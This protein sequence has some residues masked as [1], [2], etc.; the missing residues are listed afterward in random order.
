MPRNC[1]NSYGNVVPVPRL[2]KVRQLML[3]RPFKSLIA[4]IAIVA[5]ALSLIV[6]FVPAA[7]A[8]D[9]SFNYAEGGTGPVATF[10]ATDQDGDPAV[11][12]LSG[13]DAD[14]FTIE[15]GVLA[16]KKSPNYESPADEGSDNTYDVTLRAS[17]GTRDVVVIV[18]NVDEMGSVDID[19]L[20]PQAG[21][22][23][24]ASVS[25]QD[26][27]S[28]DQE[29]WQWSK[30]MSED[31]EFSDISGATSPTYTPKTDDIGYFLQ[32]TATYSDGIGEGRDSASG[33]TVF[34]VE[35]RP[36]SNAQ[37]VFADETPV[38]S[39]T[40]SE[41]TRTV[42]E[43]AKP[44]DSVGNPVTA[45]DA[46]N[47]PRLYKLDGLAIVYTSSTATADATNPLPTAIDNSDALFE[48]DRKTGQI[49]L[50]SDANTRFLNVEEYVT[51]EADS[52][53]TPPT[54]QSLEYMVKVTATDPSGSE[55]E[56][57]VT[58]KVA[59]VDEAP[60]ITLVTAGLGADQT[61]RIV[62][63]G[64]TFVVT[65]PEERALALRS[66]EGGA[67]AFSTGLPVFNARDPEEST[68]A[69]NADRDKITW[70]ISGADAKRFEIAKIVDGDDTSATFGQSAPNAGFN[71]S[72]ALRWASENNEGPSFEAMDSA[73]GDNVYL[74]T[75]TAFDG[76]SSTSQAV[77]I[78]VRNEEE[79]GSITLSQLTP[80]VG[81]SV[82]ASL[83]D[84]DKGVTGAE[85]QWYR[86]GPAT[87]TD[88]PADGIQEDEIVTLF[89]ALGTT[90]E[91][92][93]KFG[94]KCDP[95]SAT[96]AERTNCWIEGA[97]S[98]TY[99]PVTADTTGGPDDSAGDPTAQRLTAVVRYTDT[100]MTDNDTRNADGT[101]TAGTPDEK[102]DGDIAIATTDNAATPRPNQN[103]A[104][105]FGDD[106][107]VDR[108]VAENAKDANV[109]EPVTANDGDADA[110]LYSLSGDGHEAFK[111]DRKNG[112]IK[113]AKA[114]DFETQS[115]YSITL[116]ATD[117]SGAS[118]SITVNVEVTD[119]DDA[120]TI[121]AVSSL[122]Y[123]EGG[124]D[125]VAT[126]T[127][128]DQDGDA[129][130]WS[131]GGADADLFTI[132]GGVLA[133]KKSPNYE[134]P[135]DEGS[136][137]IYDVTVR[138][139]GGTTDVVVTVTNV[140]EMGS[141]DIDDLQPQAGESMTASVSDQDSSSL[142]QERWQWSKSMSE[143]G[144][145]S[146]ISGA[147]S[148]TYTP[149]TDDIGYFLQATATY[150]D[151]IGE[152]RDS[153]SGVTVFAVEK[154]P[155]SNAQPVFADETPVASPTTSEQTRTV[156]ETAKPG[157]SVGN[158][159]TASDA[160][161]DPRLYKLDGLAITY[162]S[163]TATADAT[164]PLPTAIGNSDALF[165]I[166]RK[167]GQIS[168]KSDAN[169]RF[170]NVEEYVTTEADST[171]TP[172]TPQS[173]EYMVKV[174]ATD[175]SGSEGEV[176]VTIKVAAVD[177][178]PAITLVTTGL[179]TGQ[180]ARIVTPGQT[181]VVTTPE[182]RALALRSQEG[183]ADA[184][185]TGLPVFNA[186][187]PEESTEATNADR[188][189]ITWSISGADAK[190]FEIAKIVNADGDS[191]PNDNFNSSAALRW[192]SENNEGPS[193]EAMDSADGDNVY[194]VTV[195]AFDG[196]SSTSQAVSITVR[197]EEE[198]G[199][200]TLSQL[201]PQVGIS[202]T[203]S[204]DDPDKG[205]TGAE[206]QWYRGGGT[207]ADGDTPADG[208]QQ[209]EIEAVFGTLATTGENAGKFGAKCD[210]TSTTPAER[211]NCWIEGATSSTYTPVAAD[212]TGGPA[213]SAGD[214]TA[215]RL[216]AVVRYT[217]TVVTTVSAT[218]DTEVIDI[219][220]AT[221][222]NAATPRPNQNSA[223]S[224][225]DDESVDR[226]VAE[227]AKDANVG[228]PVTANDGDADALLYSLSGDG[229]EAFK[230]D[231]KNGQ[232]KTAKAL[233]FETQSSYSITLTATDP[234]GASDS[235]T[236]N[237]EVT[238]AD[239]A[240]DIKVTT[241]NRAP[242]FADESVTIN[243]DENTEAGTAVGDPIVAT[244]ADGQEISY[245]LDDSSVVEIWP[246]GQ[247]TIA[248]GANLDYEGDANSYN[249]TL[250]ASDGVDS[251]SVMITINVNNV[252]LDNPYDADDNGE[253]SKDEA[254]TAVDDYFLDIIT[255]DDVN[256]V[257]ALYFG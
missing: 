64:Q 111:V 60:A 206:W 13:A 186:R 152:G 188:D 17:G 131:L 97:T 85:W 100:V 219:A 238:D 213:D 235:I 109:G 168:L 167:T 50:K 90:G 115:S 72:A 158:P 53:T 10:T 251:A 65:T 119:A 106:E 227:N 4:R 231:R 1:A 18:T 145:F 144:E 93:G 139:S 245:S 140:D 181:F 12:S 28:L 178:A 176:T 172:P 244:D 82:T 182:E 47:D 229:H 67:D 8:Q 242:V 129:I 165:E 88:D 83:D 7:F 68:E 250:T 183:G 62:T 84:S 125:P 52:T 105:S 75:V 202:V 170:L 55:G 163:S 71:S 20:Q 89:G 56:V 209:D 236:V 133:F 193:F 79:A 189:K 99:T 59:A 173:L 135:A 155:V 95:T 215:Q 221:T 159:V 204:L 26:S 205:V 153:A 66:Q 156:R 239:D 224:F 127:A 225:G 80:Q 150:S 77:S 124:T 180:I 30:S 35:K 98:S 11:W 138:A 49:S 29:R 226:E 164:N 23:M 117:P 92:A 196:T 154:R 54:P 175:P 3:K 254:I 39:P 122:T 228:E 16:F 199:S 14:L 207:I 197:N 246:S 116:T 243:V 130:V 157:D 220:I 195:T 143:D 191:A 118:D 187:D 6:P 203:A 253:I 108:E 78:T 91:N 42:R 194:L 136:D 37:P 160:D 15:G 141:V 123:A 113:T 201:T 249:V 248:E 5:L 36:V 247:L 240:A 146:D 132:E 241:E 104:P 179:T 234:S 126:F 45:S 25:D 22:S 40:T 101:I 46:D 73:D 237:V 70:S 216:T 230:V 252:G 96:L 27:S 43:T 69:T 151:G 48:I 86:G 214:P 19:D 103:S 212:T 211:T 190:R 114:L 198:A 94:A 9:T 102:D 232:I 171:T 255:R 223:P 148:P 74:V 185:S 38:A 192:A 34:A 162:T 137:N 31:G 110:L 142:D 166:D 169:T 33:V 120:A 61:A 147:T 63:P 57:T 87:D 222:D 184:F 208:I 44:G 210:P 233:D 32:A 177:E 256:A 41:Q 107:S 24:T 218:D 200:I 81:I 21:E 161:N 58:I 217:D 134:S 76:T 121:S 257:L 149:K 2:H 112:Q 51:T 174:T 128:D